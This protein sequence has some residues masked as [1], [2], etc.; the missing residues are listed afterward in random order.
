MDIFRKF[1]IPSVTQKHVRHRLIL[2]GPARV[3]G[4]FFQTRVRL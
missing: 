4:I 1:I 3:A 2:Q